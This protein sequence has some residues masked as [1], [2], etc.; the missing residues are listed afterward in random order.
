MRKKKIYYKAAPEH[1]NHKAVTGRD[2][3]TKIKIANAIVIASKDSILNSTT[4][5]LHANV[6]VRIKEYLRQEQAKDEQRAID[7]SKERAKTA[8]KAGAEMR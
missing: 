3:R 2:T 1:R 4:Q 8:K 6:L 7:E 5:K